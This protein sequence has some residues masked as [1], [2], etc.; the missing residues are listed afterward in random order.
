MIVEI[1]VT[2]LLILPTLS[3]HFVAPNHRKLICWSFYIYM[4]RKNRN[5]K[6]IFINVSFSIKRNIT[7]YHLI[8]SLQNIDIFVR[9]KS[10]FFIYHKT[11]SY[12]KPTQKNFSLSPKIELFSSAFI[13][14]NSSFNSLAYIQIRVYFKFVFRQWYRHIRGKPT[15]GCSYVI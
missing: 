4:S 6:L 7:Y 3:V 11:L 12:T 5:S 2:F 1:Y 8:C 10:C 15:L 9:Y 13:H 14:F